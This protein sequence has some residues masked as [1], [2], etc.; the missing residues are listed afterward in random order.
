[1]S[2][3]IDWH[4]HYIPRRVYDLLAERTRA[5]R[6]IRNARGEQLLLATPW[7]NERNARVQTSEWH[8]IDL[9]LRR[10]DR[11]GVD[12]QLLSWPT[13]TGVDAF[14]PPGDAR[15]IW[16]AYNEELS[17]VVAGHPDRLF[18]VAVLPTSDIEWAADELDRAHRKLGLIG[19]VLPVGGFQ[20]LEAARLFEPVFEVAQRH[21][22]HI[23]LHTGPANPEIPGQPPNVPHAEDDAPRVRWSLDTSAQ[24]A[25]GTV[26]LTQTDFLDAYPDVTIQ[27]AMLGGSISFLAE[28]IELRSRGLDIPPSE[29]AR[30][31][32]ERFRRVYFDTGIVGRGPRALALAVEAF[33]ADRILFGSDFPP[34]PDLPSMVDAV[35]LA[36]LGPEAESQIYH[37]NGLAL[38]EAKNPTAL[39]PE[40]T[41]N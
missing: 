40:L 16:G 6:A 26:T 15:R 17:K 35:H 39:Q 30:S 19:A 4:S 32:Q 5:P 8:D 7:T 27:I 2:T 22:S 18:G 3:I 41:L 28:S 10:L 20:T 13:T 36:H 11:A 34:I 9:R 31:P 23:Y 29:S 12:K 24:F 1:M 33:G 21:R 37:D 14:L 38:L 25:A